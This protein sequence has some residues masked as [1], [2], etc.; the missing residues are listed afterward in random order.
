MNLNPQSR[1]RKFETLNLLNFPKKSN[2]V[3]GRTKSF[4][5]VN[6]T[7]KQKKVNFKKSQV[8]RQ[9]KQ[10]KKDVSKHQLGQEHEE[11]Q[12]SKTKR[13]NKIKSSKKEHKKQLNSQYRFQKRSHNKKKKKRKTRNI[14]H[15]KLAKSKKTDKNQNQLQTMKPYDTP[16]SSTVSEKSFNSGSQISQELGFDIKFEIKKDFQRKAVAYRTT[17]IAPDTN[18]NMESESESY[19]SS[20][21]CSFSSEDFYSISHSKSNS[22]REYESG[23]Y[24]TFPLTNNLLP[25][26]NTQKSK[27]ANNREKGKKKKLY[28]SDPEIKEE[29]I[30]IQNGF[31]SFL[32]NPQKSR[33]LNKEQL[34]NFMMKRKVFLSIWEKCGEKKFLETDFNFNNEELLDLFLFKE[35]PFQNS[36]IETKINDKDSSFST[37]SQ[38]FSFSNEPCLSYSIDCVYDIWFQ[39]KDQAYYKF[40]NQ[41]LYLETAR[42]GYELSFI[43]NGLFNLVEI[44]NPEACHMNLLHSLNTNNIQKRIKV[45]KQNLIWGQI[46][47]FSN[48]ILFQ[49]FLIEPIKYFWCKKNLSKTID[50]K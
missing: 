38:L 24:F 45:I 12:Q 39:N 48:F 14:S 41:V 3:C 37:Q 28:T 17:E 27:L 9:L 6:Q 46:K 18:S 15:R 23:G 5:A 22:E 40:R 21:S 29:L 2:Q 13:K 43:D 44:L 49:D 42:K 32:T 11:H 30:E 34:K 31:L 35:V 19:L 10:L 47:W 33:N 26:T 4:K 20:Q 7:K 1:K 25:I 8:K 16:N 36:I 50:N